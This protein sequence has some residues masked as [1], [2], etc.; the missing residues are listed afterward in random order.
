[1]LEMIDRAAIDDGSR[2]A[3]HCPNESSFSRRRDSLSHRGSFELP[4]K[5]HTPEAQTVTQLAALARQGLCT[6]G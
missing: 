1:M 3:I 6:L 5:W 2:F 4:L